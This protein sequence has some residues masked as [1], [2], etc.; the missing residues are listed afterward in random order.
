MF[1]P[2]TSSAPAARANASPS[3]PYTYFVISH[4]HWDREWYQPFQEFRARLVRLVDR[5]LDLLD[6]D[7]D[8]R[9]FMLDGQTVV[10]ED[11]LA[12]RPDREVALRRHIQTG[13]I[14]VGPWF[15]LPDEFLVGPESL[16]RNLLFGHRIARRFGAAM[17]VGYIPDT[18]GH[19]SQL[20]QV[21]RGFGLDCAAVWRGLPPLPTEFTWQAPDGSE[22]LVVNL[23]EGYGDL[24]WAPADPD[25]FTAAVRQAAGKLRPHTTTPNLLLTSGNDHLEARPDLPALIAATNARLALGTDGAS[26]V[27]STLPR[28]IA[29]VRAA[30][31]R[32]QSVAGEFR[33][34]QRNNI[35]PGVL[36]ARM[37]LKQRNRATE[38]L[39]TRWAEPFSA[40]AARLDPAPSDGLQPASRSGLLNEAWR[41]L[42]QNQP[43]DSICG[44]SI[45]QV[46][47]EMRARF[48]QADQIAE[49]IASQSL[50][51]IA[52]KM[53]TSGL[54]GSGPAIPITAFNP[55]THAADGRVIVAI[56]IP[57]D[58]P[59]FHLED[60]TGHVIPHQVMGQRH[61]P[62]SAI[63]IDETAIMSR[64]GS[65]M[66]AAE[67][68]A[69]Q[70]LISLAFQVEGTE[71]IITA[72]LGG[73]GLGDST[74]IAGAVAEIQRLL[75]QHPELRP[76]IQVSIVPC[77]ELAFVARDVPGCGYTTC[78]VR[79]SEG[80][81]A[82]PSATLPSGAMETVLENDLFRLTV[83]ATDGTLTLL[84][85]RSGTVFSGLNRFVDD[86]D[87]GDEYNF[88]PVED[89]T[90]VDRPCR[91]PTVRMVE[92]GPER[93][94]V[95]I[96]LVYRL[97]VGL[98]ATRH[99]RAA[100]TVDLPI[101]S[102]VSLTAGL[103]RVDLETIIGNAARDHRL[104]VA[105]PTPIKTSG[106]RT[107][108][109]FDI[110]ERPVTPPGFE[111][112]P[113]YVGWQER[114][115][116]QQPQLGFC[117]VS[118]K[119]AGL[120]LASRGLP[121]VEAR[122]DANGAVTLLLTLL[123]CVGWL[124]RDDLSARR[125]HAGPG[126]PT[127]G[128]QCLGAHTVH[129]SLI[130]HQGDWSAVL[131]HVRSFGAPMRA[132]A[133]SFHSGILPLRRS[134]VAVEPP[135]VFL[136]ALKTAENG[137]GLALRLWNAAA[138]PRV[139]T[140]RLALPVTSAA[141]AT[142]NEEPGAAIP[143][144]TDGSFAVRLSPHQAATILLRTVRIP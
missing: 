47:D 73:H 38:A 7:P 122:S 134:F 135:D 126:L 88:C 141:T 57:A 59:D 86:G 63:G 138:A 40:I 130:P 107:E 128:A 9:Y 97:P 80:A 24:A 123:R 117:D 142:F 92:D 8:F 76:R 28:Y 45:D 103:P 14:L 35:L 132:V 106:W 78:F 2:E 79:P 127:P 46:H 140:V 90:V 21:F 53:N 120:M 17:P 61:L 51:A 54:R 44:C 49:A 121:E 55:C 20:P 111:Q 36:S 137:D 81:T 31:P 42:L 22:V 13:R 25:G 133:G 91:P 115:V 101:T 95:E 112:A 85:K 114:P 113:D 116:A 84:D 58:W 16:I 98:D 29:A 75:G 41:L 43:H 66:E 72:A 60:E 5:L 30:S 64:I 129:Y 110:V 6:A 136:S 87:R 33:C 94:T 65:G 143:L 105:F 70:S 144:A 11:Y 139:A 4:T 62:F 100:E 118:G 23:R 67:R 71:L 77:T 15:I 32:L 12:V 125:G 82:L 56:Q 69:G 131:P 19:I 102:R 104:R 124:S 1:T 50:A 37:W 119:G 109:P 96:S 39:L 52:A 10:L 89:D 93:Q 3:V 26:L 48:D 83:E 34:S 108:T 74:A 68:L 18:F 27:H 99:A